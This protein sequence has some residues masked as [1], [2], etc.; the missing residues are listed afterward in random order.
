[1][2]NTD[3]Q[4]D[5]DK[6]AEK[7]DVW[8]PHLAPVGEALLTALNT[9]TGDRV[10]DVATGTGEPGLTL[11]RRMR[12]NVTVVGTDAAQG[13]VDAA[14]RKGD[15]EGLSNVEYRCMPAEKL[16]F[17]SDSFD[18][19]LCRFGVMLFENPVQGLR[20]MHRVL[21]PG[22][23]YAIA[24]WSTP[25]TMPTMYW[26]Y[27]VFKDKVPE[28][29]QPP[30]AKVTSLG[31]PGAFEAALN[32]AGYRDIEIRPHTFHYNFPSFEA[33]WDVV[34]ASDILKMQYDALPENQRETV[35]DE[36]ALLARDFHTEH[37]L[38]IPHEFLLANGVK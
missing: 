15:R 32:E 25:E 17:A 23:R 4:P 11:A 30:M 9:E 20:E 16:N 6:I 27:H 18:K 1:M 38:V 28:E 13:M 26:S 34:E 35:R 5:W 36:V 2:T 33:F 21:K 37:G 24:V 31:A 3:N 12:S 22:G 19:V 29:A 10:L 7:F 14:Q 8:L